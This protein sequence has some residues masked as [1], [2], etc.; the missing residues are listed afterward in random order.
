VVACSRRRRRRKRGRFDFGDLLQ[1]DARARKTRHSG[2]FRPLVFALASP[3]RPPR[4]VVRSTI[5]G[6]LELRTANDLSI[7]KKW[8]LAGARLVF[9]LRADANQEE[10]P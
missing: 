7:A 3:F 6:L 4:I 2:A 8:K 10:T 5:S 1:R 9:L